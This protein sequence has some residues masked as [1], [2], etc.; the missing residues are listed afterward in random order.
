MADKPNLIIVDRAKLDELLKSMFPSS[1]TVR[2]DLIDNLV[3]KETP[4]GVTPNRQARG[5][6]I[7]K[8]SIRLAKML[9]QPLDIVLEMLVRT[10]DVWEQRETLRRQL[11]GAYRDVKKYL[12]E[13]LEAQQGKP[14]FT[15]ADEQAMQKTIFDLT[16]KLQDLE[17]DEAHDAKV[18]EQ[19]AN[20]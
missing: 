13:R 3:E 2:D 7:V 19:I 20:A 5:Q 4:R 18:R 12:G 11:I 14:N 1:P 17:E 10:T 15:V 6:G 16:W 8:Q 9:D